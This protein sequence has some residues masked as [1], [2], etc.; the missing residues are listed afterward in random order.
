M[1]KESDAACPGYKVPN[2]ELRFNFASKQYRIPAGKNKTYLEKL[3]HVKK[4]VPGPG[5]YVKQANWGQ[6]GKDIQIYKSDRKTFI[7]EI[8]KRGKQTP[9]I[10]KYNS[11]AF[12]ERYNKKPPGPVKISLS[13]KQNYLDEAME[14]SSAIPS[15]YEATPLV[16]DQFLIFLG[17]H[18]SEN[19]RS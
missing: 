16:S 4:I 1:N 17:R 15:F 2:S 13:E 8:H 10:G 5:N 9:G 14:K 18:K 3:I 11:A 19:P 7:D 6:T 12:D